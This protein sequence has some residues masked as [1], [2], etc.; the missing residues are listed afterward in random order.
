MR[1][2]LAIPLFAC[3]AAALPALVG[4]SAATAL[5]LATEGPPQAGDTVVA[6]VVSG[7]VLVREPGPA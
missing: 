6:R 7:T 2:R 1:R 5:T 3:A 4:A